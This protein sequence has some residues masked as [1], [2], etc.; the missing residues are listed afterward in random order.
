MAKIMTKANE[1]LVMRAARTS[2][3][4]NIAL[5]AFQLF[6]G[7]VANSAAM[8]SDAVHAITDLISTCIAVVG[9]K[10]SNKKA[11]KD[12]PYGHERFECV[13]ALVLAAMVFAVG[14]GIGW[15]GIERA[16]HSFTAEGYVP[17]P[18]ALALVGALV[19]IGLKEALFWYVRG[20]AKKVDS[21]VLMADAWH[22]RAD[23]LSSIGSFVGIGGAMLGFLFMDGLAAVV[24]CVFILRT[25]IKIALDA[26]KKMTD[27]ACDEATVANMREV[28][29]AQPGVEGIDLLQT[30]LFGSRIFVDVEITMPGD[31]TLTVAHDGAEQVHNA[32]EAAFPK[33]K[34]C[35]VHVN[36]KTADASIGPSSQIPAAK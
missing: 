16:I 27:S 4:V 23:G 29:L 5:A 28:I 14:V 31:V 30:R 32:I 11:D 10:L 9:I 13:A 3:G 6:A 20:V 25:A 8:V 21:D 24:I 1:K 17:T 7:I 15:A 36:P 35:M 12:H 2:I 19:G 18:G 34:H 26:L 22:S 33:V